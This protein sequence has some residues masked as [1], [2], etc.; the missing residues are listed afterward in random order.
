M[1]RK[2]SEAVLEGNGP[3]PQLEELRSDPP[4]LANVHQLFEESFDR[5]LKVVKSYF[6]EMVEEMRETDQR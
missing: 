2:E 3:V 5:Q 1:S 6:D 4:T